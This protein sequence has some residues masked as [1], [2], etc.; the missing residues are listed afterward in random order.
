MLFITHRDAMQGEKFTDPVMATNK[1]VIITGTTSGIGKATA[2][3]LARR[4]AHVY[5]ANRNM[6]KCEKIRDEIILQTKNKHVYCLECDLS[7]LESIQNFVKTFVT[8]THLSCYA[9]IYLLRILL[10]IFFRYKEKENR[11]DILINNAGVM[12]CPYKLTK[13]GIEM[14]LGGV[15]VF[16]S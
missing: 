13:D 11:L 14:Q 3:E 15:C 9:D 5:M 16:F 12:R 7:S 2:E 8:S 4:E 1:R 10:S 6:K